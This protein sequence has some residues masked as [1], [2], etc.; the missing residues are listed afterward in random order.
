MTSSEPN[1]VHQN[2]ERAKLTVINVFGYKNKGDSAIVWSI[3][4]A[5]NKKFNNPDI[6]IESWHPEL[7]QKVYNEKVFDRLWKG[8][9]SSKYGRFSPYPENIFEAIFKVPYLFNSIQ[10]SSQP[11]STSRFLTSQEEAF[12]QRLQE[13]DL[14]ISVGGGFLLGSGPAALVHL[15][16]LKVATLVDTPVMIYAQSIGPFGNQ[17]ISKATKWVL[18]DVDY[19]TI[20]D[21]IS[22]R[23]L[24]EI[25][26]K[27][28]P[29]EVTADAAFLIEAEQ[30]EFINEIIDGINRNGFSV[31]I[32]VRDWHYPNSKNPDEKKTNYRNQLSQFV[33]YLNSEY[34]NHIYFFSHREK[35]A[36]EAKR[37][38]NKCSCEQN[39]T[40]LDPDISPHALK[41]LTGEME[42]FI[43]TRMHSTIFSMEMGTPTISIA[44]LPKSLD[45][46]ERLDLEEMVIPIEDT[47]NEDLTS[48]T[49][50]LLNNNKYKHRMHS[51]ISGLRKLSERNADIALQLAKNNIL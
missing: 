49:K 22:G 33:E 45:L 41:Y 44:Y 39:T 24:S 36:E 30:T 28:P 23:Y 51:G 40:I 46:M 16:T 9:S 43:G 1:Q 4:D 12:V 35:D 47:N 37:I 11:S 18:N 29:I 48:M 50:L 26:V 7:D 13:S 6:A 25:G 27:S 20:R 3:I 19:I 21:N 32:T 42:L 5:L 2:R 10:Q 31:G 15:Y 14:I 38:V 34:A 17:L 8:R